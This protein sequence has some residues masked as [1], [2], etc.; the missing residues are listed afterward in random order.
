MINTQDKKGFTII[1]VVLVLGIAAL[2]FLMVFIAVPVLNRNQRDTA[3]KNDLS[4]VSTA[5]TNYSNANRGAWPGT[6]KL[7]S[8]LGTD[9]SKYTNKDHVSVDSKKNSVT[10]SDTEIQVVTGMKC[11]ESS[12]EK[13]E[14]EPGTSRQFAVVVLRVAQLTSAKTAV[15]KNQINYSSLFINRGCFFLLFLLP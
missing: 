4:L 3:R 11:G 13:Q 15:L 8:F 14:L 1:E 12:K 2:I 9:L 10:V 7:R 6:E 5:V